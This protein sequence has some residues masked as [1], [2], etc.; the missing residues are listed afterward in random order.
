[1]SR[2]IPLSELPKSYWSKVNVQQSTA[3]W[4]WSKARNAAGYGTV[5]WLGKTYPTHRVAAYL[6][7]I[8]PTLESKDCILHSCDNPPCCNPAHLR[9]GTQAEN[10]RDMVGRKRSNKARGEASGRAKLTAVQVKDIRERYM[11]DEVTQSYLAK[12]FGVSTLAINS[13]VRRKT[14]QHV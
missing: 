1:M 3:C 13:I 14:W 4:I 2:K 12:M 11:L 7:G 8:I 5:G 6:H 10:M 9:A